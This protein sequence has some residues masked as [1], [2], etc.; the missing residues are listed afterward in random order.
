MFE[1]HLVDIIGIDYEH[2]QF[3]VILFSQFELYVK[4]FSMYVCSSSKYGKY[5]PSQK[6]FFYNKD[7]LSTFLENNPI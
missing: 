2:K 5:E 1:F 7:L 6:L 3:A 4:Y